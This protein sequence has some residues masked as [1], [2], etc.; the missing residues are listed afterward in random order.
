MVT[1][2]FK[3]YLIKMNDRDVNE[4]VLYHDVYISKHHAQ[5]LVH[6]PRFEA[7]CLQLGIQS[8]VGHTLDRVHRRSR[9]ATLDAL[10]DSR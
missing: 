9:D 5:K 1:R 10:I 8:I 7:Y 4:G 6:W 3:W 2:I